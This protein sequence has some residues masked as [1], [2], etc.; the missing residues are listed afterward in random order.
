MYWGDWVQRNPDGQRRNVERLAA[1][2]SEGRI[3]PAV[4]ERVPLAEAPAAMTRLLER[5]VKG[6]VVV[7]PSA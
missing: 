3:K 2:F 7:V 5:K 6:K 4:S 1:W